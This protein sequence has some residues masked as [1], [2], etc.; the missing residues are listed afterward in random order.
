VSFCGNS[1]AGQRSARDGFAIENG[2]SRTGLVR[3][4]SAL[5]EPAK[6]AVNPLARLLLWP[7]IL[8]DIMNIQ[9][10]HDESA[11]DDK[12]VV[13]AE[14]NSATESWMALGR[15]EREEAVAVF[16]QAGESNKEFARRAVGQIDRLQNA[17]FRPRR[18]IFALQS[19]CPEGA[20]D[21]RALIARALV[22]AL[23]NAGGV[24]LVLAGHVRFADSERH[25]LLGLVETLNLSLVGSPINIRVQFS[26]APPMRSVCSAS[27]VPAVIRSGSSK[28]L[29]LAVGA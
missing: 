8:G 6:R 15:N 7:S 24:E 12:I 1:C 21:A 10:S 25:E 5:G 29:R 2:P 27:G 28:R 4:E 9:Q 23:C 17:R 18:A 20:L 14:A 16:Q 13:V 26:A 19:C 11:P 22:A 3:L